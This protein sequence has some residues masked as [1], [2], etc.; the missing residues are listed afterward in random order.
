[1]ISM[2]IR[3]LEQ[4]I[5]GNDCHL[6]VLDEMLLGNAGLVVKRQIFWVCQSGLEMLAMV[7]GDPERV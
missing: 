4:N 7:A 1:M 6:L 5:H 2:K 3:I